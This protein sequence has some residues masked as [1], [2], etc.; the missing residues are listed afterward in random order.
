MVITS[1]QNWRREMY[2]VGMYGGCFNP[3]HLGHV[4]DIIMASNM[5]EKLYVIL[6]YSNNPNEIPHQEIFM[7]L[8]NITADLSNIQV[9]ELFDDSYNKENYDW[10]K[11]AINIKNLIGKKIDVVFS[12]DDYQ[13]KNIWERLYPESIVHYFSREEINISSTQ[14]RENPLY[15]YDYLPSCVR[16]YYNKKVVIVGT[17]S[18][19]KSTLVQN[20][21]KAYNTSYVTEQGRDVCFEAGG[22]D[23]MQPKHYFE[24]LFRHKKEESDKQKLANKVLFIDTD[25]LITLYYYQLAFQENSNYDLAF[26]QLVQAITKLN[27]YDLYIFL[28]PDVPWIQDGTRTYGEDIVRIE[29]NNKLKGL[30]DKAG[31]NYEIVNGDYQERYVKSK[32]LVNNLIKGNYSK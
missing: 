32:R 22:I 25:A 21:A 31:I 9:L 26:N 23:N 13:G 17:E 27:D 16:P 19:G 4:N 2:K 14:I 5:C 12:G 8:K 18:C 7:C 15:Y 29:N 11:G 20:L 3:L 10:V 28:E 1:G 6:S 30:F 24:I